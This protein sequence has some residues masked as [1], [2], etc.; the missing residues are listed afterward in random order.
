[1]PTLPTN[2]GAEFIPPK[3]VESPVKPGLG[4]RAPW[5]WAA[6]LSLAAL[7]SMASATD[8]PLQRI[9]QAAPA[10]YS[11]GYGAKIVETI[12]PK[13]A[14]EK[15]IPDSGCEVEVA[16]DEKGHI[17]SHRVISSW[18]HAAWCPT[19]LR[20]LDHIERIPAD[21]DGRVPSRLGIMFRSKE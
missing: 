9:A 7:S 17:R 14:L 3:K 16:L 20:A 19:V 5:A 12:K 13:I 1:M 21:I 15:A 2:A 18:G 11:P 6:G 10:P 8:A 4:A